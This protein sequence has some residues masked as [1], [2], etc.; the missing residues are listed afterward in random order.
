MAK[1]MLEYPIH[2]QQYHDNKWD[3]TACYAALRS[4]MSHPYGREN[5]LV[6]FNH[7]PAVEL[8]FAIQFPGVFLDQD[9]TIP[10][11]YVGFIDCVFFCPDT[12]EYKVFDLKNTT[13]TVDP[14]VMFRYDTQMLPYALVLEAMLGK[15]INELRCDYLV[16]HVDVQNAK[17]RHLEFIK[18]KDDI[19]AWGMKIALLIK[20]LQLFHAYDYFPRR[21]NAC[22][23]F[24]RKCA[25][26]DVCDASNEYIAA[27]YPPA[28]YGTEHSDKIQPVFT[29]ELEL[30]GV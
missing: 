7:K 15:Q 25:F 29:I 10:I 22:V 18:T 21:A 17:T 19:Q 12:G 26:W 1:L 11:E 13:R 30:P 4:L 8:A 27:A 16:T 2:L 14:E 20:Q 3:L 24:N 9:K 5:Q 28:Q 6:E 23:S